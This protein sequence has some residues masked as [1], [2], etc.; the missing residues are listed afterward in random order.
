MSYVVSPAPVSSVPVKDSDHLYAVNRIYCVGQNYGD[1]VREMGGDP[2]KNPPVFFSKPANAIVINNKGVNYPPATRELHHEVELVVALSGGGLRIP[3]QSAMSCVYGYAVGIDLTC[4]DLQQSAK[5]TGRPW[6]TAKGFDQSAPISPIKPFPLDKDLG[7][8]MITLSLNNEV[9]QKAKLSDMIW[10]VSEII[11]ALS[12]FYELKA[13]DL[14][15]TGTP[16]GVSSVAPGDHITANI[17]SV[18]DLE[19]DICEAL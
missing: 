11:S 13:G 12:N 3:E 14:I 15:F 7:D 9:R 2:K 18:G 19:F 8:A 1:H 4:R 17:V 16:S 5:K 10:S 6:D